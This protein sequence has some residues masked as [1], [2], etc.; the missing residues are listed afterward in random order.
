M[1]TFTHTYRLT[2]PEDALLIPLDLEISLKELKEVINAA[3]RSHKQVYMYMCVY[4]YIQYMY[5]CVYA[6]MYVCM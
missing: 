5:V 1:H 2:A 6:C 3:K 4:K